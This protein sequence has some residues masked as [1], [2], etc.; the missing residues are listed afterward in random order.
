MSK[1][2]AAMVVVTIDAFFKYSV[3]DRKVT[4][5]GRYFLEITFIFDKYPQT[6]VSST[7]VKYELDIK[8]V[9]VFLYFGGNGK[10]A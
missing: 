8:Y 10:I 4:K 7:P 2:T 3:I 6:S 9:P 1:P 5:D